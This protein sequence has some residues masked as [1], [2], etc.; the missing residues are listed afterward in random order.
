MII[1]GS[2]MTV[3]VGL[4][5]FDTWVLR[6]WLALRTGYTAASIVFCKVNVINITEP[7]MVTSNMINRMVMIFNGDFFLPSL[8][9]YPSKDN[10]R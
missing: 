2:G 8:M 1:T 9:A 7:M 3:G 6:A 10:S 4:N 5:S